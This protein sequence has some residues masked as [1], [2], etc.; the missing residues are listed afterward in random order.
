MGCLKILSPREVPPKRVLRQLSREG[1]YEGKPKAAG[2]G[3]ALGKLE[4]AFRQLN[5]E[6]SEQHMGLPWEQFFQTTLRIFH[7]FPEFWI[8]LQVAWDSSILPTRR[9]GL[10]VW[11]CLSVRSKHP[12]YDH[13]PLLHY[14]KSTS[15]IF[16]PLKSAHKLWNSALIYYCNTLTL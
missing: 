2:R 3:C 5:R 4:G 10:S 9:T 12:L 6:L 15:D 8:L 16:S 13:F 11:K 1:F 14:T 7:S